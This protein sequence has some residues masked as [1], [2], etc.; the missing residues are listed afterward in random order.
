LRRHTVHRCMGKLEGKDYELD[1]YHSTKRQGI[2]LGFG[3]WYMER[4]V[5]R[6]S[7]EKKIWDCN[8]LR[9][10]CLRLELGEEQPF[11][12][13]TICPSEEQPLAGAI[14]LGK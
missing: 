14:R 10:N 4:S 8:S 7:R 9:S 6:L 13:G 2:A 1:I 11:A 12:V 5:Y 3:L